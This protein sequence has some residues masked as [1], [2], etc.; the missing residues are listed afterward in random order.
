MS[1]NTKPRAQ[2]RSDFSGHI[3]SLFVCLSFIF[4]SGPFLVT[5]LG[6]KNKF[7]RFSLGH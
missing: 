7:T 3:P 5:Y 4:K 2:G 6:K 1:N